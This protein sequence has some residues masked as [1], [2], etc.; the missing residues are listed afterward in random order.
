MRTAQGCAWLLLAAAA[1]L[2]G[3]QAA[4]AADH[5]AH[6]ASPRAAR[7]LNQAAHGKGDPETP[8][9]AAELIRALDKAGIRQ[10]AAISEAYRLG[11]PWVR[12]PNEAEETGRENRWTAA[13]A[14]LYPGR[15]TAFCSVNPLKTYAAQAIRRCAAGGMRGLKLHLANA[16][17]DFGKPDQVRRLGEIFALADRL[18]MTILIHLRSGEQWEGAAEVSLF[19]R[20][21]LPRA[22]HVQVQVAHLTGW[23]GYDRATD[24][25]LSELADWC[26]EAP[27]HCDRLYLD[28]AAVVLPPE[29]ATKPK[30]SDQRMLADEEADFPDGPARMR[31]NLL[32]FDQSHL[33]FAT[34]WPLA[35]PGEFSQ[36]L[37]ARLGAELAEKIAANRGPWLGK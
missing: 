14:A 7:L 26:A 35:D 23:G 27:L 29:A 15:L 3:A 34:D 30:G 9:T 5:H 8:E 12:V 24:A 25:G 22:P 6:L 20:E 21:V 18:G 17:F 36:L 11:A 2:A 19:A 33:L 31:A 16:G 28:L 32:R 1:G 10:A 13:Q 37:R 4:P